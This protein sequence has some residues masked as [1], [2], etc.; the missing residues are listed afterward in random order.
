MKCPYECNKKDANG[1]CSI[2]GCF[3]NKYNAK[4]F[5]YTAAFNMTNIKEKYSKKTN[6]KIKD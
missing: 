4:S 3:N 1:Y 6:S 5:Q 2:A